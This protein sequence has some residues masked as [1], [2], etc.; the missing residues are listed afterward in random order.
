MTPG[1]LRRSLRDIA[2]TVASEGPSGGWR[3]S[4]IGRSS[5][6][7][8]DDTELPYRVTRRRG[9]TYRGRRARMHAYGPQKPPTSA[10]ALQMAPMWL[11]DVCSPALF[12]RLR[13]IKSKLGSYL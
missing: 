9:R 2:V 13:R 4:D 12:A 8:H 10:R 11:K 5:R 3:A 6:K 7:M 1:T